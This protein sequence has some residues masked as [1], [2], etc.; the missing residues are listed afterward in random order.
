MAGDLLKGILAVALALWIAPGTPGPE[1][2]ALAVVAGHI[3]PV[4]LGF[5][6][7]KGLA[8][9]FG[10][11]LL[12]APL[13]AAVAAAVAL[14]WL[15]ATRRAVEAGLLGVAAMPVVVLLTRPVDAGLVALV[16]LAGLVLMRHASVIRSLVAA[17]RAPQA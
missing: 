9:A 7:G 2:A 3:H 10:S 8:T 5:R 11:V 6:G 15:G 14:A 13:G 16:L 4:Q 17:R 12:A 1:L